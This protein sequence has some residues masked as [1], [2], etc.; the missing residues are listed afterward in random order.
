MLT[1]KMTH[2]HPIVQSGRAG[3]NNQAARLAAALPHDGD[4]PDRGGGAGEGM[5]VDGDVGGDAG[6]G[7]ADVAAA[8]EGGLV[9]HISPSTF[10]GG[11]ARTHGTSGDERFGG[12]GRVEGDEAVGGDHDAGGGNVGADSRGGG[13][14]P[15]VGGTDQALFVLAGHAAGGGGDGA[16][17]D[18][19]GSSLPAAVAARVGGGPTVAGGG[20][21]GVVTVGPGGTH[22]AAVAVAGPVHGAVVGVGGVGGHAADAGAA[23][24]HQVPVGGGTWFAGNGA[25]IGSGHVIVGAAAAEA[26][27]GGDV[28]GG[29][30]G[31]A[32]QPVVRLAPTSSNAAVTLVGGAGGLASD[33]TAP[34][35][36]SGFSQ[37]WQPPPGSGSVCAGGAGQ[38]GSRVATV[39]GAGCNGGAASNGFR[40]AVD[41]ADLPR[42]VGGAGA[43]LVRRGGASDNGHAKLVRDVLA[44]KT[45]DFDK[46]SLAAYNGKAV[47]TFWVRGKKLR[48]ALVK[49]GLDVPFGDD[50]INLAVVD[51]TTD[52]CGSDVAGVLVTELGPRWTR[53]DIARHL[54]RA[55]GA[56]VCD[57][58]QIQAVAGR[59]PQVRATVDKAAAGRVREGEFV[60][61][62]EGIQVRMWTVRTKRLAEAFALATSRSL[63]L[64]GVP[65]G[66][67]D[68]QLHTVLSGTNDAALAGVQVRLTASGAPTQV[69]RVF[70][71]TTRD[72]EMALAMGTVP[73]G[74]N[75]VFITKDPKPV[76]Y[77]CG[78]LGHFTANCN[79]DA[80]TN[81][82]PS[83]VRRGT[84]KTPAG[85]LTGAHPKQA[86]VTESAPRAAAATRGG[87]AQVVASAVPGQSVSWSGMVAR[88]HMAGTEKPSRPIQSCKPQTLA[89]DKDSHAVAGDQ[90]LLFG[91]TVPATRSLLLSADRIALEMSKAMTCLKSGDLVNFLLSMV[92]VEALLA[93]QKGIREGLAEVLG[94]QGQRASAG[95]KKAGA[96]DGSQRGTKAVSK[97]AASRV[98][99]RRHA[100]EATVGPPAATASAVT[101]S[102]PRQTGVCGR[103]EE[104]M[105]D[106]GEG[107][108]NGARVSGADVGDDAVAREVIA[109]A[110]GATPPN[111]SEHATGVNALRRQHATRRPSLAVLGSS[112]DDHPSPEREGGV[113]RL[114]A[115]ASTVRNAPMPPKR[116]KSAST[117]LHQG[118][119]AAVAEAASALTGPTANMRQALQAAMACAHAAVPQHPQLAG[120]LGSVASVGDDP[121][122]AVVVGDPPEAVPT[123]AA[124]DVERFA[125]SNE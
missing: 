62:G 114:M 3:N 27:I 34:G 98:G 67:S 35:A 12:G 82:I 83:W 115:A 6:V 43:A 13:G 109:R 16:G 30:A 85:P 59:R 55:L 107:A 122:S 71:K 5:H 25:G 97:A 120:D 61:L 86:H 96:C 54:R 53:E 66:S 123:A 103:M 93:A 29:H 105:A 119:L 23:G 87:K 14:H 52:G 26:A 48:D 125:I 65:R 78:N 36:F 117:A 11:S 39:E 9:G 15:A 75:T 102:Q 100:V 111:T 91:N 63:W 112:D 69:A 56:L 124:A 22:A 99:A 19:G 4:P 42:L 41:R 49:N 7:G 24:M 50:L 113:P 72:Y 94:G 18:G 89:R 80:P 17:G 101:T 32:V 1:K 31:G 108:A 60:C 8:V 76:C 74:R 38:D 2:C 20:A 40:L 110:N 68:Q 95:V 79:S 37:P 51:V 118:G 28:G 47:V 104:S 116:R 45:H 106:G 64:Q 73:I 10:G 81:P 88:G 92:V 121:H 44:T 46:V 90:A 84:G 57:V 21:G 77:A 58:G 70:F 33:V